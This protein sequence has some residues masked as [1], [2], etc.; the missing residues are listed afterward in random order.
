MPFDAIVLADSPHAR[1]RVMGLTLVERGRRVAAKSG[2]RRVYVVDSEEAAK[3]VVAWDR[4]RGD[5]ALVVV[6][7][8]D[9]VVHK[10]LIEPLVEPLVLPLVEPLVER[11]VEPLVEPLVETSAGARDRRIAVSP[12]TDAYAGALYVRGDAS[13]V[14]AAIAEQRDLPIDGAQRIA[15]GDIAVHPATTPTE[16]AGASQMLQRLNI[17]KEDNPVTKHCYRP[18][19]RPL[20]RLLVWTPFT[21]NQISVA[22][23][24]LGLFGCWLTAQPGQANLVW[25]AA[26]IFFAGVLD[27]CDGEIARL[28]LVYS[29]AGAWIDTVVDEITTTAYFV[30]IAYHVFAMHPE[31]WY[32]PWVVHSI[33]IGTLAYI[34]SIYA[35]YYYCIVVAKVGGSQ[36]YIG[37]LEVAEGPR[38][39]GLRPKQRAPKLQ[40]N[41]WRLVGVWLLTIKTRDFIN[42]AALGLTFLDAYWVIY[43]PMF[44]GGVI[45]AMVVVPEHIRLRLQLGEVA[46]R[47]GTPHLVTT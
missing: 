3:G 30:A 25:G 10:Q 40:S 14:I 26:I 16:R 35:I 39:V 23:G 33:W 18:L 11:L 38:G 46:R 21:P 2:A 47:G 4:D 42:L 45:T 17:K 12:E 31:A 29:S 43:L 15:H 5:A 28:K 36:F 44:F 37:T 24:V 32:T 8:G 6:R 20:T 13:D 1:A 22:V 19:S 7:A 27:G 34:A 41:G 9:Q